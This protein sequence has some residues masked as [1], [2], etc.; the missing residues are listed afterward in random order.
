[1]ST[2]PRLVLKHPTGWFAAGREVAEALALLPDPAFRLYMYLCLNADRHTGEF[3]VDPVDLARTL[4]RERL[5]IVGHLDELVSHGV[6]H[7]W[8]SV[9]EIC[10]RFWPYQK[11]QTDRPDDR[12]LEYV[13]SVR[14][15]FLEPASTFTPADEKLAVDLYRRGV[16]LEALQRAIRLGCAR[17]YIAMLN[18]QPPAPIA[19]LGY[20]TALLEEVARAPVTKIYWEHVRRKVETLERQWQQSSSPASVEP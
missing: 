19:S 2:A 6:C 20:F 4:R 13:R 15:A 5:T 10:D 14:E 3:V 12:Q 9:V 16:P 11:R 8:A 7:R 18:G 1:M 17:K